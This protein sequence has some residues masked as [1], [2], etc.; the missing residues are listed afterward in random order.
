M[1]LKNHCTNQK[2]IDTKECT[3]HLYEIL[4]QIRMMPSD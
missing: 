1:N 3:V 2:Q 4:E